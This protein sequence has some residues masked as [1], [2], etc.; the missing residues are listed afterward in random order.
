MLKGTLWAGFFVYLVYFIFSWKEPTDSFSV[1]PHFPVSPV[2][3]RLLMPPWIYL[4]GLTE[5][6]FS[7]GSRPTYILGHA[8]PHGVWFYFPVI[9]M[10]KSQLSFLLLLLLATVAAIIRQERRLTRTAETS[11]VAPGMNLHWR[12]IWVSLVVYVIRMHAQP[13]GSE[14]PALLHCDRIDHSVAC[15]VTS[16]V[17]R[18]CETCI[19]DSHAQ[20]C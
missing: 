4:R 7:A 9:F 10:L 19:R 14:H 17:V 16:N 3:R 6:A 5:F 18:R 11:A 15:A 12:C 1:I 20:G 13:P 2:L 8:Y